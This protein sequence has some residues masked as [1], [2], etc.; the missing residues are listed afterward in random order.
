MQGQQQK[1][2]KSSPAEFSSTLQEAPRK[3]RKI[4]RLISAIAAFPRDLLGTSA[5][6]WDAAK[7]FVLNLNRY[8]SAS[9]LLTL[10]AM[11]A[12]WVGHPTVSQLP[13]LLRGVA[14]ILGVSA[15]FMSN[16]SLSNQPRSPAQIKEDKK[17]ALLLTCLGAFLV[18]CSLS[19]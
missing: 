8:S 17:V 1:E 4:S 5:T 6:I 13:N 2:T 10:S 14:T 3:R 12:I 11:L 18:L 9:V 15:G 7:A 19:I 16:T